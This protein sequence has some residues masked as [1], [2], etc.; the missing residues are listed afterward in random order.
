MSNNFVLENGV[1][2][3][4]A[5]W[6][7]KL[8]VDFDR[9]RLMQLAP[10]IE[11]DDHHRFEKEMEELHLDNHNASVEFLNSVVHAVRETASLRNLTRLAINK[12]LLTH[13][14]ATLIS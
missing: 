14:K 2:R 1:K 11:Y 4:R 7:K 12:V 3:M 13:E 8:W 10:S 9:D 5:D 6:R